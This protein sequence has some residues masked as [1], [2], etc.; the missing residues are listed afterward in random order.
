MIGDTAPTGYEKTAQWIE[1]RRSTARGCGARLFFLE[2]ELQSVEPLMF[3][4]NPQQRAERLKHVRAVF[5]L[6]RLRLGQRAWSLVHD[7]LNERAK[8]SLCAVADFMQA[9]LRR[10]L[11]DDTDTIGRAFDAF[12][13]GLLRQ[14][15]GMLHGQMRNAVTCDADSAFVF[16][17]AE[18]AFAFA[19]VNE[20]LA[21]YWT[22]LLNCFIRAQTIYLARWAADDPQCFS[23]Y[24]GAVPP[25]TCVPEA[26][27][28][29]YQWIGQDPARLETAYRCNLARVALN[30]SCF[31]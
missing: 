17:F 27:T 24:K 26:T 15:C 13:A 30:R 3:A 12:A 21:A 1:C 14:D 20:S 18:L 6:L 4:W 28:R 10:F 22:R 2:L 9:A 7:E 8:V 31:V 5:G 23:K 29:L 25:L 16:Y 19:E 11:N